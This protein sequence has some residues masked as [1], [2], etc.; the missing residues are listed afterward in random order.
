MN[1]RVAE[2]LNQ[3]LKIS[4]SQ[5]RATHAVLDRVVG[6]LSPNPAPQADEEDQTLE[7]I[8][9]ALA[10]AVIDQADEVGEESG[11]QTAA[12]K[13]VLSSH[14]GSY[15]LRSW[16]ILGIAH[17]FMRAKNRTDEL[18]RECAECSK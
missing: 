15:F 18:Y 3:H 7:K 4:L 12:M 11:E 13:K 9:L 10:Q 1:D 8:G 17:E 2:H 5:T 6:A 14:P 16:Q